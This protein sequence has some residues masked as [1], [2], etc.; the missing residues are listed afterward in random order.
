M[1]AVVEAVSASPQ[2]LNNAAMASG[3]S[4]RFMTIGSVRQARLPR[5]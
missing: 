5:V 3:I 2:P 4:V 1:V